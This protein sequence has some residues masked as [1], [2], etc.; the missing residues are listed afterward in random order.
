MAPFVLQKHNTSLLQFNLQMS[1][2]NH[3]QG[4]GP[5]SH[6][7]RRSRKTQITNVGADYL[8]TTMYIY[9]LT[10]SLKA[11][12]HDDSYQQILFFIILGQLVDQSC[13][14]LCKRQAIKRRTE[15]VLV[16][17]LMS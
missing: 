4:W 2:L 13:R 7:D 8:L 10:Q 17:R 15:R 1:E 12:F 16:L 11:G 5:I 3:T 14:L 9:M 6:P